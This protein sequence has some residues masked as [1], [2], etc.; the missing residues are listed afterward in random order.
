MAGL[1]SWTWPGA[2][3]RGGIVGMRTPRSWNPVGIYPPVLKSGGYIP[4]TFCVPNNFRVSSEN[5]VRNKN[6]RK[7]KKCNDDFCPVKVFP[8]WKHN[9]WK[10]TSWIA[11]YVNCWFHISARLA[12]NTAVC[13]K[14]CHPLRYI[15]RSWD[16]KAH[17]DPFVAWLGIWTNRDLGTRCQS[18]DFALGFGKK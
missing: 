18:C 1:E 5:R 2:S 10:M 3:P 16:F 11:A 13:P 8:I 12:R 4:T 7:R 15:P 14:W 6:E 17:L 9:T